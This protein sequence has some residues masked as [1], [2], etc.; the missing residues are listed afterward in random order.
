MDDSPK[1]LAFAGSG[2]RLDGKS[3]GAPQILLAASQDTMLLNKRGCKVR[4]G[5]VAGK[6]LADIARHVTGCHVTQETRVQ[7]ACQ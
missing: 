5:D 6:F 7:G 3:G 4:V 2:S 1:F